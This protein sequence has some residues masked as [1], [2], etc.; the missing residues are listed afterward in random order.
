MV[1]PDVNILDDLDERLKN[2]VDGDWFRDK[3]II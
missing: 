3:N 2:L 1:F